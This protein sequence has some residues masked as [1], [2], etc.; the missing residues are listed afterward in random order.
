MNQVLTHSEQ[1]LPSV[2]RRHGINPTA[3]RLTIAEVLLSKYQHMSADQVLNAVNA[4]Q[5]SV[6]KA[7]VY[8]TLN[9]FSEKGLIK[10]VIIDPNKVFYDSNITTHYHIYNEDSGELLDLDAQSL[11]ISGMPD[12]PENTVENGIDVIVRVRAQKS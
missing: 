5:T 9:L 6:S 7:T 10:P 11:K 2:L 12:L 8:N 3:Q 1:D 4:K